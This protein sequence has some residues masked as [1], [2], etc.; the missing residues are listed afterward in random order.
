MA[1]TVS[2]KNIYGSALSMA[3]A[4]AIED[5]YNPEATVASAVYGNKTEI[6][7]EV[8]EAVQFGFGSGLALVTSESVED[9]V[10]TVTLERGSAANDLLISRF[11]VKKDGK[12]LNIEKIQ[13]VDGSKIVFVINDGN[14]DWDGDK[15][16]ITYNGLDNPAYSITDASGNILVNFDDVEVSIENIN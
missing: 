8:G 6:V 15:L 9:G 13:I 3:S 11:T 12:K 1:E 7:F 16:E 5:K 14:E 10:T 2:T 4:L